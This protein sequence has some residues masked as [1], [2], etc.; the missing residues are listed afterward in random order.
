MITFKDFQ[1]IHCADKPGRARKIKS[2]VIMDATFDRDVQYMIGYFYDYYHDDEPLIYKDLHPEN[3]DSKIPIE[4]KFIVHQHNTENK[5]QVGYHIQFKTSQLNPLDYYDDVFVKKWDAEFP[6]GLYCDLPDEKGI[7]RKW[8]VT[9]RADWLG[10]QF[11]TWYIL[12]IDH[13]Y[14]W[15]Y[16]DINGNAKRYQMCGVQRSQSSY[17]SGVWLDLFGSIKIPLIAGTSLL[18]YYYNARMR[19]AYT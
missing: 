15:I 7:Y 10:L 14:Q 1:N 2:D 18:L 5:D 17:N 3:S 11:P 16:R 12:P 6:V 13:V 9:E 4:V 19:N 8:L